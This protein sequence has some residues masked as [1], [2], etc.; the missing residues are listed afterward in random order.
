VLTQPNVL[1]GKEATS[2]SHD[3]GGSSFVSPLSWRVP[4]L[5]L[6]LK[7]ISPHGWRSPRYLSR[8]SVDLGLAAGNSLL[9]FDG[10]NGYWKG[11]RLGGNL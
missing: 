3:Q 8:I 2:Q 4:T 11:G 10:G 7:H 5:G 6:K 9:R 1:R